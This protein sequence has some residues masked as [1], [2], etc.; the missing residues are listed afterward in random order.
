[1]ARIPSASIGV[2]TINGSDFGGTSP[3]ND[4]LTLLNNVSSVRV[5]LGD[6]TNT[7]NLAAGANSLVDAGGINNTINGTALDDTLT[8]V[9]GVYQSTINLGDGTDTLILANPAGF[10]ALGLVGVE[11]VAGGTAD[12]YI[13]L[14]NAVTGVTFDLGIGNDTINLVNGSNSIGVLG[15]ETI[16]GS[17]FGGTNPSNDTLTLLNNVNG[18]VI[19]LGDGANAVNLAGG[20]NSLTLNNIQSVNGTL[21]DDSLTSQGQSLNSTIDLG[22]GTDTLTL[23]GGFNNVTVDNVE[24]VFGGNDADSIVIANTT[25]STTVTGG[26][27]ADSITASAGQDNIRYTS[28]AESAAGGGGDTVT[29]FDA[30]NDT[31]VLDHVAGLAGEVHFVSNGVFTGSLAD[32]HSEARLNGNVLQIDVD[33]DGQIGVGDMEIVLN[34][35]NGTLTDAN[36]VTSGVNHAPTDISLVG[37]TVAENSSA[38]TIVGALSNFDPD[39]GDTATYSIVNPTGAFGISGN[40]LVVAGVLDYESGASQQVTVRVTDSGGLTYDEVF[41]IGITDAN[42]APAVT[43]GATGSVAE[44]AATSTVVYQATAA[45]PDATAPNNAITWSLTGTDAPAFSIDGGGNVRLNSSADYEAK[46]SYS[47]NV[48]ATDGG[49]LSSSLAVTVNVSDANDAPTVTSGGIGSVAE[50]AAAGAAVYQA[51]ASD[52]DGTAPNNTISWSL[53]R[54]RCSRV[55]HRRQRPG[56]AERLGQL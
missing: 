38:G 21:S 25:G 28:S 11:N 50:N 30:A 32:P 45:D 51:T 40:N 55:Q 53:Y 20:A 24:N 17:D 22:D 19:N 46:S 49:N 52:P 41:N 31:I 43:S 3:S 47:I 23:A 1:M 8:L 54:Y 18:V 14:Q 36:F 7:L 29:N 4:T 44:N 12:E 56:H 6:G 26:L 13:V 37:S 10:S 5:N 9:N 33:G 2:E 27:G 34:G 15:V 16:N 39:A 35:L 48:V 42:D